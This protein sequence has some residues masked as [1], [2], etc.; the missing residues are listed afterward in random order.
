MAGDQLFRSS[1]C[2]ANTGAFPYSAGVTILRVFSR[3]LFWERLSESSERP[4]GRIRAILIFPTGREQRGI[5]MMA[6][7]KKA[8][9]VIPVTNIRAVLRAQRTLF[10]LACSRSVSFSPWRRSGK[11]RPLTV[12]GRSRLFVPCSKARDLGPFY[13]PVTAALARAATPYGIAP[14]TPGKKEP[15]AAEGGQAL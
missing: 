10:G 15:L 1:Q 13:W 5:G 14:L 2:L 8:F 12:T 4:R 7:P 9:G 3:T 11:F 6:L